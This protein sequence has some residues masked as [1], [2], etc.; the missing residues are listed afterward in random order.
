MYMWLA[1]WTI[2]TQASASLVPVWP[3]YV[4]LLPVS[5]RYAIRSATRKL[6]AARQINQHRQHRKFLQSIFQV[7]FTS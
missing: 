3:E 4:L 5:V 6:M 7:T 1:L 2:N